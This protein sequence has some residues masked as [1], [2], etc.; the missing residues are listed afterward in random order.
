MHFAL[1]IGV[2]QIAGDLPLAGEESQRHSEQERVAREIRE[3]VGPAY[4]LSD[5]SWIFTRRESS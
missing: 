4:R 3:A 5:G 2:A 1:V